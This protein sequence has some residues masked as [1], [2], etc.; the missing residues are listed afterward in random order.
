[1]KRFLGLVGVMGTFLGFIGCATS[2][3]VTS[4]I[5]DFVMMGIKTNKTETVSLQIVSNIHDGEYVVLNQEGNDSGRK[6]S[7]MESS[8]LQRMINEYMTSKFAELSST[9]TTTIKITLNDFSYSAYTT[10]GAGM[11]ALRAF[12]GTPAG[13]PFIISAK[14]SATVEIDRNGVVETKNIISTAEQ[15]FINGG[16]AVYSQ[17]AANCVNS[18][19]NKV[20]MLLN[21]YFEELQL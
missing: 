15:N 6:V 7:F 21:S 20:L 18:V 2:I 12:A 19:N 11:Q 17:E 8:T 14:I 5:N 3:P 10:E 13:Q 9:G 4:N 1:M 16:G